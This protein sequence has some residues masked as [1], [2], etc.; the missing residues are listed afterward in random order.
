MK[1]YT[2][3]AEDFKLDG[4]ACF[5]VVPK[6]IWSKFAPADENN[7]VKICLRSLLIEEGNR[8]I[9]IDTG[10]GNK[11]NDKFLSHYY[12]FG[13]N[14]L[15]NSFNKTPY[16]FDDVTDVIFTHLHFDHCGG[17][18]FL[19]KET[20]TFEPRFK[21]ALYWV[22]KAQWEL[23]YNPNKREKASFLKENTDI[24]FEKGLMRFIE[25]EQNITPNIYLKIVNGHTIGQMIPIIN[26]NGKTI[27]YTADFI[28]SLI[29]ISVP[30]IASY[31]TQPLVS[32][33]EKELFLE[34]AVNKKFI[35]FFEHDFYNECCSVMKDEKG[36][37]KNNEVMYLKNLL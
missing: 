8:L 1:L 35:L 34:E 32:M 5:G 6:T 3:Y 17:A 33:E 27:V 21:N 10:I 22:S 19:K 28:P 23:A 9:L 18:V 29:N 20:N 30:Y 7:M 26:Y 13:E 24:L 11:Q 31:D 12:I 2:I 15:E 14:S 37:F 16:S 25:N 4:G 36:R